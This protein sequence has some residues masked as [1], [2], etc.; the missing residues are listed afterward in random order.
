MTDLSCF[1]LDILFNSVEAKSK[2]I[3]LIIKEDVVNNILEVCIIDD[4][5]GMTKEQ[6]NRVTDPFYTSRNTRKVGLGIPFYKEL[7][8]QCGGT[9]HI[10]SKEYIGT[11][12]MST[13]QYNAIDLPDIGDMEDTICLIIM[14]QDVDLL[15]QHICHH[16]EFKFDTKEIKKIIKDIPITNPQIIMWI[17][18]HIKTELSKLK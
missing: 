7:C 14:N 12:I 2:N 1:L 6:L 9:F 8:E 15:Y 11:T 3:N 18:N 10:D 13:F 16:K 4:G 17:K 5:M